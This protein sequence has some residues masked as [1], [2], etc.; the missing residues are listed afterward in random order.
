VF[1][2]NYLI[3]QEFQHGHTRTL[4]T[5]GLA[6]E[7]KHLQDEGA[8][9][10]N[11][12]SPSHMI[13]QMADAI[14]VA[15]GKGLVVPVVYNSNGYD[16]VDALRQIRGL[17]DIY[18]PDIKYM[19][20]GLGKQFSAVDDYADIVPGV[21]REM[22]DQVGHLEM[23][24]EGIAV[25]GLLVRHLVLP[26]H[27]DNSRRCL[28]FLADLS[29]DTFVSIMAQY[30]PQYKACNYPGINRALTEDEYNEVTDYALDIGLENAYIQE[31]E[32]Q[33]HYLPDFAQASPFN[34]AS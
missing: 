21:L 4:T 31:L 25:R 5:D 12:V 28:H 18:L 33:D 17:V 30:S 13:F 3:S 29:P 19:E 1:C 26:N 2:Q 23:D 14:E 27:L 11:F 15:R 22:L 7:M 32:S 20:N 8:H 24:D 10:I 6:D 34:S 9:N 16:S